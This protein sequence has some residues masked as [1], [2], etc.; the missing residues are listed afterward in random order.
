VHGAVPSCGFAATLATIS[1]KLVCM[2][3]SLSSMNFVATIYKVT[4]GSF[5]FLL[6]TFE[7][8]D[9]DDINLFILVVYLTSLFLLCFLPLIMISPDI[10]IAT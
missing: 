9:F 2:S 8:D 3:Y 4:Q 6:Y 10:Y 1:L 5:S 7:D